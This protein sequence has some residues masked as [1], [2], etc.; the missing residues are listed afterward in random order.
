MLI[1]SE[2]HSRLVLSEGTDHYTLV[3]FKCRDLA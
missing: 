3:R 2:R 1:T